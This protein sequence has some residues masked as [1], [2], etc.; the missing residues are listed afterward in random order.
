MA[1]V[2]CIRCKREGDAIT[3]AVYGGAFGEEIKKQV[4]QA[5]WNEWKALSIK[6]INEYRL[7][8]N[9]PASDQLLTQ[10]ARAFLTMPA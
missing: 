3:T 2:Q 4:C 9:D 1:K 6:I 5:C 10:Q 8:L 7:D